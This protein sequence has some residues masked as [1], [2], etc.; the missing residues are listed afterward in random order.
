MLGRGFS[1]EECLWNGPRT[2]SDWRVRAVILSHAFWQQHFAGD[3]KI[4]GTSITLNGEPAQIIGVMPPSFDFA[5]VFSPGKGVE[6][7]VPFPLVK[8]TAGWGNTIFAIGRLNPSATVA[9]A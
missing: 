2:S 9:R 4:V 6:L 3:R 8:E 7:F 5:S 1:D